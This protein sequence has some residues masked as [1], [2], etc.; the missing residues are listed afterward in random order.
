[1]P[2]KLPARHLLLALAVWGSNFWRR[3]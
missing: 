2:E 3:W 1:M